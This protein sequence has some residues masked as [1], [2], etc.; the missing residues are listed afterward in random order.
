M[1][2]RKSFLSGDPFVSL[3]GQWMHLAPYILQ[4]GDAA[5][6]QE[7]FGTCYARELIASPW[8]AFYAK[9]LREHALQRGLQPLGRRGDWEVF[10]YPNV[11]Q[12]EG[13]RDDGYELNLRMRATDGA[14]SSEYTI[15][16]EFNLVL[17]DY[18][19]GEEIIAVLQEA[20]RAEG[21]YPLWELIDLMGVAQHMWEAPLAKGELRF[22]EE[23]ATYWTPTG[24]SAR[25]VHG[26]WVPEE[27]EAFR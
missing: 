5:L 24:I 20:L 7:Q 6:D 22:D 1:N 25:V 15:N 11:R 19:G 2:L 12:I 3:Q 23:G 18:P 8:G 21:V 13:I 27:L 26:V 14:P 10:R 9:R 17:D 16:Q 4:P